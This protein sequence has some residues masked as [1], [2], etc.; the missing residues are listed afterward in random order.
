MHSRVPRVTAL[1]SHVGVA[2][3]N[4]CMRACASPM[5]PALHGGIVRG[6]VLTCLYRSRYNEQG[7]CIRRIH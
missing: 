6:H 2:C 5:I 1:G 3:F 7:S 4:V